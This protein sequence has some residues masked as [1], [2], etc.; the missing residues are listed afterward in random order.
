M[1][2]IPILQRKQ[3]RPRKRWNIFLKLTQP[4]GAE[5]W[6]QAIKFETLYSCPLYILTE[7]PSSGI[8]TW[9][10]LT[11]GWRWGD[12]ER[13]TR[14]QGSLNSFIPDLLCVCGL[15]QVTSALCLSIS[16]SAKQ[17]LGSDWPSEIHPGTTSRYSPMMKFQDMTGAFTEDFQDKNKHS[18]APWLLMVL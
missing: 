9:I 10:S 17:K 7:T 15:E 16:L 2:F 1:L 12:K 11:E 5:V 4:N 3:V 18:G 8:F 13:R 6:T 14:R